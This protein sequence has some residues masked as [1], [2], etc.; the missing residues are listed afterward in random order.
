MRNPVDMLT[1]SKKRRS[2]AGSLTPWTTLVGMGIGAGLTYLLDP[3]RGARRRAIARDRAAKLARDQA[4]EVDRNVQRPRHKAQGLVA[5]M[6]SARSDEPTD[7]VLL[8]RVRSRLGHLVANPSSIEVHVDNGEVT[9]SGPVLHSEL[10]ELLRGIRRVRGV[11][12][13]FDRLEP[14]ERAE[15]VPGLQGA[16][17]A[18]ARRGRERG[19]GK[20]LAAGSGLAAATYVI[21]R[22]GAI[23]RAVGAAGGLVALN[24]LRKA[25]GGSR[26]DESAIPREVRRSSAQRPTDV[27]P[28]HRGVNA[29]QPD[30]AVD[31]QRWP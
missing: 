14:H 29:G 3:D 23:G 15:G 7:D 17:N 16:R 5:R 6:R 1:S 12:T 19:T 8:A 21:T 18:R 25:I 9:L 11:H 28:P 2:R 13:V 10:V 22:P 4:Q 26:R 30:L 31:E 27:R 24:E 20:M